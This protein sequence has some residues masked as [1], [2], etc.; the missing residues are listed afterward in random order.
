M[1]EYFA[2]ERMGVYLTS[3]F[4]ECKRE[5]KDMCIPFKSMDRH[6][7]ITFDGEIFDTGMPVEIYIDHFFDRVKSIEILR[8]EKYY[9]S[10]EVLDQSFVHIQDELTRKHSHPDFEDSFAF[11]SGAIMKYSRWETED[12]IIDHVAAYEAELHEY[13]RVYFKK[14]M[15]DFKPRKSYKNI[16]IPIIGG[17]ILLALLMIFLWPQTGYD[18]LFLLLYAA[19]GGVFALLLDILF[20]RG[21]TRGF[22]FL[23]KKPNIDPEKRHEAE[24][25]T[26]Y[27]KKFTGHLF[28]PEEKKHKLIKTNIYLFSDHILFLLMHEGKSGEIK[29]NYAKAGCI[30]AEGKMISAMYRNGE[31]IPFTLDD[32]ERTLELLKEY[33]RLQKMNQEGMDK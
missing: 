27:L 10:R 17:M 7:C 28:V 1:K 11:D 12:L 9:T 4:R 21:N 29:R 20:F 18:W 33:Q 30:I 19:T 26:E 16:F 32:P 2:I 24:F 15:H 14:T 13:V 5:L 31:M 8:P 22:P 25:Q 23:S 3:S 6:T